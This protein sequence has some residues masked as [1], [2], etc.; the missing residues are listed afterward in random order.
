[1]TPFTGLPY[2]YGNRSLQLSVRC[3]SVVCQTN[4]MLRVSQLFR[5]Y[6]ASLQ[7]K[8]WRD[9]LQKQ[10]NWRYVLI[11]LLHMV[12]CTVYLSLSLSLSLSPL[13]LQSVYDFAYTADSDKLPHQ[14]VLITNFPRKELHP[15]ADGG[16]LLKDLDLGRK[17]VLFVHDV[18]D[19]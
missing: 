7:V 6:S 8:G 12:G 13:C 14:F 5:C 19:D 15:E 10:T 18:S 9:D 17:C 16:P 11:Y 3:V 2:L 1:M 4:R